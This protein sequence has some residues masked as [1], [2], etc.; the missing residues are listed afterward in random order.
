[1]PDTTIRSNTEVVLIGAGI[2]SATLGIILKELQPDINEIFEEIRWGSRR[3]QMHGIM[4]EQAILLCEL[5]YTLRRMELLIQR[6]RLVSESFE[7]SRQFWSYLV[8][9][10]ISSPKNL[11]KVFRI[12][13]LFG[14]RKM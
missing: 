4:Q 6:K 8:E 7:V 13:A 9:Q 11:S 12:S 5:N 2:M 10:K 14:V 3:V 1:M